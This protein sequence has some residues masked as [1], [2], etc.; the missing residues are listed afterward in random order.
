MRPRWL[1]AATLVLAS[2]TFG[3]PLIAEDTDSDA[4]ED[5]ETSDDGGETCGPSEGVVDWVVDGDTIVL[6]NGETV[7]YILVDT[8][9]TT[10]GKNDCGGEAATEYNIELVLGQTIALEYDVECRDQF[11]RL[12]A[13]VSVQGHVVNELLLEHGHACVLHI[14]PNGNERVGAYQALEDTAKAAGVGMWGACG[15]VLCDL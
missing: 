4:T 10:R 11:G 6:E 8:P 12:L 13:Y 15:T 14:P 9:E 2:C 5:D 3:A 7:R 1:I